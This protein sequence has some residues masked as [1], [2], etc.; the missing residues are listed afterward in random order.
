MAR[1]RRIKHALMKTGYPLETLRDHR[2]AKDTEPGLFV[3]TGW[4]IMSWGVS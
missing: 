3:A 2:L 4:K 1:R